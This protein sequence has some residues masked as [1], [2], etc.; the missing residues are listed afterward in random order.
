MIARMF[1]LWVLEDYTVYAECLKDQDT[2]LKLP[3]NRAQGFKLDM[4]INVDL[5]MCV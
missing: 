4:Y 3:C 1:L 2:P 5:N